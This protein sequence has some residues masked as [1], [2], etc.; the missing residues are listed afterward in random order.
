MIHVEVTVTNTEV[1][2][3]LNVL[4]SRPDVDAS[5]TVPR[6]D[7]AA[8]HKPLT[9]VMKF[10]AR[11]T[12]LSKVKEAHAAIVQRQRT[13]RGEYGFAWFPERLSPPRERCPR[14]RPCARR[15]TAESLSVS[16]E[17]DGV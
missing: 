7:S 5:S 17:R 1:D 10:F 2:H 6:E 16:L 9:S 12:V 13:R 8:L 4:G 3:E 11:L 14:P 15:G